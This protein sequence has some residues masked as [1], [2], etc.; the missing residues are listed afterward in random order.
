MAWPSYNN[1]CLPAAAAAQRTESIMGLV[2]GAELSWAND[3][4]N[5]TVLLCSPPAPS[6]GY[7][8][9]LSYWSCYANIS[10]NIPAKYFGG[11]IFSIVTTGPLW[12]HVLLT[13]N[14]LICYQFSLL[15][16]RLSAGYLEID[17]SKFKWSSFSP[18]EYLI[19]CKNA[20]IMQSSI[21][22]RYNCVA[23]P[24]VHNGGEKSSSDSYL[25][26]LHDSE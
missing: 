4:N 12:L 19:C 17:E 1:L 14:W 18:S 13:G 21:C 10:R 20:A 15:G 9:T 26:F 7:H 5:M 22:K 24:A 6:P 2:C 11:K 25:K 8:D 23:K 3:N 16:F